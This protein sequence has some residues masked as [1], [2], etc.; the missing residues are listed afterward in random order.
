MLSARQQA[1]AH[2]KGLPLGWDVLQF[3]ECRCGHDR[4]AVVLCQR[5]IEDGDHGTQFV[6][7]WV[8]MDLGGCFNGEYVDDYTSAMCEFN[9]RKARL[10]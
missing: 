6:V 2:V 5:T 9:R 10:K 8:N 7:W 4:D 1:N 3:H